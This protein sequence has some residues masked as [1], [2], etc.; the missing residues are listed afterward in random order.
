MDYKVGDWITLNPKAWSYSNCDTIYSV[1]GKK[2]F[3]G[4]VGYKL[5]KVIGEADNHILEGW[6]V[7]SGLLPKDKS[8]LPIKLEDYE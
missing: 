5:E 2:D 1:V 6:W 4:V 8:E 7:K 3:A